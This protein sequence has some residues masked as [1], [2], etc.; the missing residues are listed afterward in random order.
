MTATI[1][2][3]GRRLF[4]MGFMEKQ[5]KEI[6]NCKNRGRKVK[7]ILDGSA[8]TASWRGGGGWGGQFLDI[9]KRGRKRKG[10]YQGTGG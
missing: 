7:F 9:Q 4:L 3:A 10:R 5:R 8:H 2:P 1:S 6:R